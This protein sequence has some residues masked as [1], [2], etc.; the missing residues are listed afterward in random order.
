MER[1]KMLVKD[2]LDRKRH[3]RLHAIK[4]INKK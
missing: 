4:I 3:G 2:A 1:I